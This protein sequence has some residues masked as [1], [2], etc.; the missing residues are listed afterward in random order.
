MPKPADDFMKVLE[1]LQAKLTRELPTL[2]SRLATLS[3]QNLAIIARELDFFAEL[4]RLGYS[5]ALQKLM[6]DYDD[7]AAKVLSAASKKGLQVSLG[8]A[9]SLELIKELDAVTLL[10]R[11]KGYSDKLKTEMLKGIISGEGGQS[12]AQRLGETVAKE[13]SSSNVNMIVNDSFARFSNSA[14]F[15]AI[16]DDST[17]KFRYIGPLDEV[18]RQAC[19][20]V[21][22]K[23]PE[24]GYTVDE[25]GGLEVGLSERGGFNCRHD[26]VAA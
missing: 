11:A 4:N 24:S 26:W 22:A 12:I 18:T 2:A 10:G 13:L 5:D 16:E 3:D 19:Q 8:S 15:K 14:T 1:Q 17:A 7:V 23:Q 25:I 21:L 9:Q 20:D 6:D